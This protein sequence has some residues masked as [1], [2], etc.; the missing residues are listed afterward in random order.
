MSKSCYTT[1]DSVKIRLANKVQ[2]QNNP[3]GAIDGEL[4][5]AFLEQLIS[6][7]EVQVEQELRSRYAIPFRSIK[8]GTYIDLPDHTKRAIRMVVDQSAVMLILLT[9][10]GRGTHNDGD[11]YFL[12]LKKNYESNIEK[13]LGKDKQGDG[14]NRF[15]FSP[16]LEDLML[17]KSNAYADDGFYGT[18]INTD[19]SHHDSASYAEDAVNDPSKAYLRTRNNGG[20]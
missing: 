2:F 6:D 4:S 20:L 14:V 9:D 11:Y 19:S 3:S 15:K 17:A 10:F 16:P 18:I 12:N 13:L 5:D 1:F 7:A 8:R